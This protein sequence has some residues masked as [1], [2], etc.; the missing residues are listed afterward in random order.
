MEPKKNPQYDLSYYR[1]LFFNVAMVISLS[2]I[3][4]AFEW[5]SPIDPVVDDPGSYVISCRFDFDIQEN[6]DREYEP[7]STTW[8]EDG[9]VSINRTKWE[10]NVAPND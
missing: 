2:T 7:P 5:K 8:N 9:N 6:M 4:V 3:L 10:C 1:H